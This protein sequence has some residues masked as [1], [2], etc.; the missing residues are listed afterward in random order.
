[1]LMAEEIIIDD[2]HFDP[3]IIKGKPIYQKTKIF[4]DRAYNPGLWIRQRRNNGKRI[5]PFA[6]KDIRVVFCSCVLNKKE[7]AGIVMATLYEFLEVRW[8]GHLCRIALGST[9]V[10]MIKVEYVNEY[11][12]IAFE[13]PHA[14]RVIHRVCLEGLLPSDFLNADAIEWLASADNER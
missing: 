8:K 3:E 6:R 12:H 10:T 1:M 2:P 4:G 13:L 11:K 5:D 14:V 7:G 9:E